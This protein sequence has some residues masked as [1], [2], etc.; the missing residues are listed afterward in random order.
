MRIDFQDN[1]Q[2][3]CDTVNYS[4]I[5]MKFIFQIQDQTFLFNIEL[6]DGETITIEEIK[7]IISLTFNCKV[8]SLKAV[9][10]KDEKKKA[11]VEIDDN[12]ALTNADPQK[13]F[14]S[15]DITHYQYLKDGTKFLI[16]YNHKNKDALEKRI[17][18]SLIDKVAS[19]PDES[20]ENAGLHFRCSTHQNS[21]YTFAVSKSQ[22]KAGVTLEDAEYTKDK[23][24]LNYITNQILQLTT[25]GN[26]I[27][28]NKQ[29][30]E[31]PNLLFWKNNIKPICISGVAGILFSICA[32]S[33]LKNPNYLGL[34]MSK[35]MLCVL[36]PA[37]TVIGAD[38]TYRIL[39]AC[40]FTSEEIAIS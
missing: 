18:S 36:Y 5:A 26:T 38:V 22:L 31:N 20:E 9:D 34:T 1:I 13:T 11:P 29:Y 8:N 19:V 30:I 23:S 3:N 32:T 28:Y 2:Y 21:N 39:K 24:Y 4:H 6:K 37:L 27:R 15:D 35:P 33:L 25:N 16:G 12:I 14:T 40:N 7:A 17:I 10:I